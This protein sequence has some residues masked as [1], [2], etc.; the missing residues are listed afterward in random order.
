[1]NEPARLN[2]STHILEGLIDTDRPLG[3][4]NDMTITT[5]LSMFLD[6]AAKFQLPQNGELLAPE[7]YDQQL[8]DFFHL[9][10]PITAFETCVS[11]GQIT[12]PRTILCFEPDMEILGYLP[13]LLKI[14]L[15]AGTTKGAFCVFYRKT[16]EGWTLGD[17]AVFLPYENKLHKSK[18][19]LV[20][21]G[22]P[23][24][25]L[26]DS[27]FSKNSSRKTMTVEKADYEDAF[28][29]LSACTYTSC[30]GIETVI[31]KAPEK[32]NQK[33]AKRNK[34]PFYDYHLLAV[35]P[36]QRQLASDENTTQEGLPIKRASPRP[37]MRRGYF[38]TQYNK[39]Q[40]L[41]PTTVNGTG[42]VMYKDYILIGGI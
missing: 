37:H 28:T 27:Y 6:S 14:C 34:K 22:I 12:E 2:Y 36:R 8:M 41:A 39:L 32:L 11:A 3:S 30:E 4:V 13:Q 5:I 20:F 23:F 9:P 40:W 33:R 15:D 42:G 19:D 21:E 31:L 18:S 25:L 29:I 38:R 35:K 1:M 10:F 16:S 7:S 24:V 17:T 26:A